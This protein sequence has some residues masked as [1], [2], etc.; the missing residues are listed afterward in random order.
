MR[1]SLHL[2]FSIL[3]HKFK[4]SWNLAILF[5]KTLNSAQRLGYWLTIR[6]SNPSLIKE[7]VTSPK[8]PDWLWGPSGLLLN[9]W[10][11]CGSRLTTHLLLVPR[12][13][14]SRRIP[15][16]L[17]ASMA[18]VRTTLAFCPYQNITFN[19]NSFGTPRTI[20][21]ADLRGEMEQRKTADD[22]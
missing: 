15:S 4:C 17:Y 5:G 18:C 2:Y 14:M 7:F 21:W 13:M 16:P 1:A 12:W 22:A 19:A 3:L 10:S 6:V 9:G 11:D 8:R 20:F